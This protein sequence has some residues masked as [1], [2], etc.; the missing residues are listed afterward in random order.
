MRTLITGGAGFIGSHLADAV[1]ARGDAVT[2]VDNLAT[3]RPARLGDGID[4]RVIDV[5]DAAALTAVIEEMRPEVIYHLAAQIDV[6]A[7]VA[8]PAADAVINIG[9]TINVLT[10]ARAAGARVVFASTGGALYGAQAAIPSSE[11]T[12]AEPEAPYGTAK[13]CA[14]QYLAL[15]NRLYGTRHAA[16]RLGNVY[17]PRQD[18]AGEAGVV[19]IFAGAFHAGRAPTVYGDGKATRDYVYVADVVAAF[20]AAGD[21]GLPGV[22]NIGT[23]QE[24]S[25]LALTDKIAAAAGRPVEVVHAPA[26]PGELQRSALD[27]TAA[28]RDLGWTARKSLEEGIAAV[29]A[30]VGDGQPDRTSA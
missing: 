9:G 3:G 24:T 7:S 16:L 19:S 8:D 27:A 21:A 30:W 25:V 26:R 1:A 4:R 5:T 12:L 13:L 18:P 22:W 29:V 2:V 15:F 23:G 14:E 6:R 20:I 28:R 10:A 17:G 11:D